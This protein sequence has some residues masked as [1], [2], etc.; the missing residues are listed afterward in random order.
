MPLRPRVSEGIPFPTPL[1][2]QQMSRTGRHETCRP[3]RYFCGAEQVLV[4]LGL[5]SS[6]T[7]HHYPCEMAQNFWTAI[8]AWNAGRR[9][10]GS[11]ETS[12]ATSTSFSSRRVAVDAG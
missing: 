12:D 10:P 4:E 1:P 5:R 11:C 8:F 2:R 9:T 6:A 3:F 7:L